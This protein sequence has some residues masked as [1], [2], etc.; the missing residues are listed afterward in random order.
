MGHDATEYDPR[1]SEMLERQ[2]PLRLEA[3]PDWDEAMHRAESDRNSDAESGRGPRS[4]EWRVSRMRSRRF[5]IPALAG[6]VLVVA[7]A[8]TAAGMRFWSGPS[9]PSSIDTTK[10]TSLVQYTLTSDFSIWR[11]G[12]TLALWRLP[13][14]DGS[15]CVF[16]ALSSP[17]PTAPG[18][19]GHNPFTTGFCNAQ[20]SMLMTGRP[21]SASL[22]TGPT[23]AGGLLF[24]EVRS[25]SGI[26]RVEARSANGSTP[27]AYNSGWYIGQLPS[28]TTSSELAPPGGQYAV[29]GYDSKGV[30]AGKFDLVKTFGELDGH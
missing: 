20:G 5:L 27:L 18:T 15:V 1:V 7:G 17:A 11:K 13:Q 28:S 29:V 3:R 9:S 16:A 21:L 14:R 10:A 26:A 24:G 30:V 4:S 23:P 8:A 19:N 2:V 22:S 12:D 25:G 6:L